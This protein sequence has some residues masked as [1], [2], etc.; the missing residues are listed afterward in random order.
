[1]LTNT[2]RDMSYRIAALI[3]IIG[4]AIRIPLVFLPLD[5][6]TYPWRTADTASIA[7]NFMENGYHLLYP[8][9][10]WGGSGPGY[11]ETEFQL[12]PFV[13][14]LLYG[15]FGEHIWIGRLV[16]LAITVLAFLMFYALANRLF[17]QN[18]A[19]WALAF[20]VV[21]PL[22]L[23]F[24]IEIMPE[25]TVMFF[26]IAALYLFQH[27]LDEQKL[28]TLFL[29][30]VITSLAILVKPTSIHIGIIFLLLLLERFR[31]KA[32]TQWQV[33][34]FGVISLLP[35]ILWYLHARDIFLQ[36]GNT[37]GIISGG[38]S[39]FGNLLNY[40]LSPRFYQFLIQQDTTWIVP[41]MSVFVML[42]VV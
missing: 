37:F 41:G 13:V 20:I 22:Y 29:A 12:Y 24:G 25:P 5:F 34:I 42:L 18:I 39:K 14:A 32:F 2:K 9:I 6:I 27:W 4:I 26:Y 17:K 36:Y 8:Q 33:W 23:L 19:L 15:V 7:H 38:D 16:S 11:V 31:W 10:D 28:I 35:G 21:S 3:I 1:M 40:W 30:A